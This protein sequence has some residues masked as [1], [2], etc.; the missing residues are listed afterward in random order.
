MRTVNS[1]IGSPIER[2]EDL[3]FLRGRGQYVDD[4]TRPGML[5]AAL[6]RSSVA[7]GRVRSIVAARA[8]AMPGV[9]SV[10]TAADIGRPIPHVPMRLQPLPQFEPFAQPVIAHAKVRYVGEALAVVLAES[11]ALAEDALEAIDVEI[12]SLPA[13]ADR[14][15]SAQDKSLLFEETGSN[16]AIKF[17]AVLGDAAA[18]CRDAPYARRERFRVQRHM[19]LP[20]ETRGLLAEWDAA[21]GRLT[22]HGAAKVLFF[23]RRTLAKQM[24]LAE[25]AVDL[26]E[27]D[28]GGGFGARGEFYPEDFLVPHDRVPRAIPVWH[29]VGGLDPLVAGRPADEATFAAVAAAAHKQCRP[30]INVPYDDDWRHAMVPVLVTRALRDAFERGAA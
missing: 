14:H 3:R 27:N 7:H 20:M 16:L 21:R 15:A 10:I 29:L 23:N 18:A 9:H 24:G 26:V 8:L 13:V 1:F 12:Q 25:D 28:V 17:H 5:H 22:V 11:A 6:L 30:L 2:L 4:L 19:A